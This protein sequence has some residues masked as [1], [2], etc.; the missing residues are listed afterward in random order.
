LCLEWLES[1]CVKDIKGKVAVKEEKVLD[2]LKAH[3]GK[4]SNEE[5]VWD[6]G[7]VSGHREKISVV[8][9]K[10]AIAKIKNNKVANLLGLFQKC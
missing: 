9:V 3:Y 1:G 5:L 8:E 10:A 4:L 7:R 2:T 6:V